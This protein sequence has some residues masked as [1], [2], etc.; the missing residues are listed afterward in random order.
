MCNPSSVLKSDRYQA[1]S[2]IDTLLPVAVATEPVLNC[3]F[4]TI[5][6][7]LMLPLKLCVS[8]YIGSHFRI[9]NLWLPTEYKKNYFDPIDCYVLFMLVYV[10]FNGLPCLKMTFS[11][12]QLSEN[13]LLSLSYPLPPNYWDQSQYLTGKSV[14]DG[15]GNGNMLDAKHEK[16]NYRY[17]Q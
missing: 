10:F 2:T 13:L 1:H 3:I 17:E 11:F 8:V 15:T 12:F 5:F 14:P 6:S 9:L 16:F 7:C 4:D